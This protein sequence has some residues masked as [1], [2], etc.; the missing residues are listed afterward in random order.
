MM[1]ERMSNPTETGLGGGA[2]IPVRD[3]IGKLRLADG[4]LIA[5]R[6]S[7][8]ARRISETA[9]AHPGQG[10]GWIERAVMSAGDGD[11]AERIAGVLASVRSARVGGSFWARKPTWP[12]HVRYAVKIDRRSELDRALAHAVSDRPAREVGVLLPPAAWARV[13]A[14][15]L[16]GRGFGCHL[17]P[18]DPW[19]VL[20]RV[21]TVA[22]AGDDPL[23]LLALIASRA[24]QAA[25]PGWLTGWGLTRDADGIA[26]RD[27]RSLDQ[28]AAAALISGVRYRDPF[29]G[30]AT[31]CEATIER[32]ADWRRLAD[33]DRDLACLIGVAGW[34]RARLKRFFM[35]GGDAPPFADRVDDAID[36]ARRA[37]GAIGAW[38]AA[39]PAGLSPEAD[40]A[41]VPVRQIEDGFVRSVGLGSDLAPPCSIVV[42]RLGIYFDPRRPSD[43]ERILSETA[44]TPEL[45]H[46]ALALIDRLRARRITKYNT[47]G[48]GFRRPEAARVILVP[49]QVEDDRSLVLGG[50]G[51]AGNLELVRRVRQAEPHAHIIY[52]PHPDVEAGNRVGAVPDADILAYADQIDRAASMPA[53]LD[54]VDAVHV[55]T[56]LAGFEA[57]LRGREVVTHGQPFYAGWGLTRD[58]SPPPRRGRPLSLA[59]LVAGSLILY[60]RYLDPVTGLLCPPEV[61]IERLAG[62]HGGPTMQTKVLRRLRRWFEAPALAAARALRP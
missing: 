41:A 1:G 22:V 48:A 45:E 53:L 25:S 13:A 11:A 38:P 21:E 9:L 28:L 44:F 47:G 43:L 42:D 6:R 26:Q 2:E 57:L 60:P 37:G 18:A 56:S 30:R 27:R 50:A 4:M 49:G 40:S 19:A 34:K 61:L 14:K 3:R 20:D 10:C 36:R 15:S 39:A 24:V 59:A 16:E 8:L 52:R 35:G 32:L 5:P 29:S 51:C 31:S 62:I 7:P 54:A 17:G 55:L 33:Q 23:G 46:R 12:R 58:L